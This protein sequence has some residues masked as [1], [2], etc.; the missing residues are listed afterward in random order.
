MLSLKFT[1]VIT[2]RKRWPVHVSH[3]NISDLFMDI[4]KK[5]SFNGTTKIEHFQ[6]DF[7]DNF[8][9]LYGMSSFVMMGLNLFPINRNEICS[10]NRKMLFVWKM[11]GRNVTR[12]GINFRELFTKK[13]GDKNQ[14]SSLECQNLIFLKI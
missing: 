11:F 6:S 7:S 8:F 5:K 3:I 4:C 13:F 14:C 12:V 10:N 1:S 2:I 9:P